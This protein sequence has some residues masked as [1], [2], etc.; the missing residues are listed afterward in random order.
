MEPNNKRV[1]RTSEQAREIILDAARQRLLEHGLE[2]LKVADV[3]KDVG[4]SH[5]TVLHHF[6]TTDE[7]RAALVERMSADLA[8]E[9][10]AAL[11]NDVPSHRRRTELLE[12][13]FRTLA[14]SRHGQLFAWISLH[15]ESLAQADGGASQTRALLS[16]LLGRMQKNLGD[17]NARFLMMLVISAAIGMGVS[18]PWLEEMNLLS[19]G[20]RGV[21]ELK[22]F[23]ERLSQM[24]EPSNIAAS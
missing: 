7:M 2:G 12:H 16:T 8:A 22:R 5:A 3:A 21:A 15:R 11:E 6:G 20:T 24:I 4:M 17:E 14:D 13:L 10:V 23:A 19:G 9:F 18:R 1:R